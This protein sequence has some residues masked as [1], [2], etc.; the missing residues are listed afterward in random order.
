ME[1]YTGT[2]FEPIQL[3]AVEVTETA[4]ID[5]SDTNK[6]Y[7]RQRKTDERAYRPGRAGDDDCLFTVKRRQNDEKL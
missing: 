5:D 6:A 7:L 1:N 3:Q 2:V 4:A